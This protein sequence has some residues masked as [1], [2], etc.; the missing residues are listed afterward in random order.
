MILFFS[1]I[2]N[3]ALQVQT[4]SVQNKW[5]KK[6]DYAETKFLT[7]GCIRIAENIKSYLDE[8]FDPCENFY[9]FAC[10][11]DLKDTI[12]P[13]NRGSKNIFTTVEVLVDDQLRPIISKSPQTNESKPIRFTKYFYASC[14][15]K[16]FSKDDT[17]KQMADV[18]ERL[19]GWPV[20]RG[21]TWFEHDFS[22]IKIVKQFW[23]L[24]LNIKA[25]FSLNIETDAENSSRVLW[26]VM[27]QRLINI[28]SFWAKLID[29]SRLIKRS[30]SWSLT[31]WHEKQT[32][33][34]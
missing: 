5:R 2:G 29:F 10:G 23:R 12:I 20:V 14:V 16:I 7:Q 8:S 4:N 27:S 17:I 31:F 15:N 33:D 11:N 34:L 22:W 9:Q 32:I 6:H 13:K 25:L 28:F 3:F 26:V 30:M 18:L 24:G 19:G 1:L 21:D